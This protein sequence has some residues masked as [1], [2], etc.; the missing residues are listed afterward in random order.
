MNHTISEDVEGLAPLYALGVL[1]QHE[2]RA[3]EEH[4]AEG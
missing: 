2:A 3:F 1:T 4:L